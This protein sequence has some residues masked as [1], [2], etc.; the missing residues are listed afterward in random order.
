VDPYD[1]SRVPDAALLL[2]FLSDAGAE[3]R[4]I[5]TV[6]SEIAEIDERKL[7]LGAGYP[8][9]Y[10]YCVD[11]A[12][13]SESSAYKRI[14]VART[15][16]RFREIFQALADGRLHL[17]GILLLRPYLTAANAPELLRAAEWKRKAEI[18][19][20]IAE[21][22]PR[23]E[24]L[25]LVS[26]P[27]MASP[28]RDAQLAPGLVAGITAA[29]SGLISTPAPSP[30]TIP[31]RAPAPLAPAKL[32]PIAAARFAF[33]FSTGQ[34]THDKFR[35][36]QALANCTDLEQSFDAAVDSWVERLEK[37]KFGATSRLHDRPTRVSDHPRHVPRA[38]KRA[39]WRRDRGQCSFVSHSGRRCAER[40]GLEFDHIDPVGR[41]GSATVDNIRLLCR[42]HNQHAAERAYGVGFMKAKR[43][44]A[45]EGRREAG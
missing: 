44:A 41:G 23:T 4:S 34:A 3:R 14:Q 2:T 18:E 28:E 10:T 12:R 40:A 36:A 20:L 27:L 45:T 22:F 13:Y 31:A 26:A 39:V 15:S 32:T 17:S 24:L 29:N 43:E 9:M 33:Q 37:Q 21:R 35:Y 38:V 11:V 25:P 5:A 7:Y 42:A 19:Q 30:T 6:V 16:R 1:H 8:S